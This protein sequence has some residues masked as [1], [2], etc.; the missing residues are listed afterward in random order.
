MVIIFFFFFFFVRDPRLRP[1]FAEIMT[2]LKQLQK[3]IM[4]PNVQRATPSTSSMITE[5]EQ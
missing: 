2:S 4:S 5:Q 1:S 3:P